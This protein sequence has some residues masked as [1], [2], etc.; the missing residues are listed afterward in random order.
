MCIIEIVEYLENINKNEKCL[1]YLENCPS[2]K[3]LHMEL[4]KRGIDNGICYDAEN[5]L[6][7][8]W[9]E[10]LPQMK[11]ISYWEYIRPPRIDEIENRSDNH[12]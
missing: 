9:R 11:Y 10:K 3:I 8:R 1:V 12:G 2:Y 4:N 6:N 7:Y 5:W